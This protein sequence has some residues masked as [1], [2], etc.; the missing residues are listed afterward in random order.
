LRLFSDRESE[1]TAREVIAKAIYEHCQA[2][3]LSD[4]V[5]DTVLSGLEQAG[6][7]VKR[8]KRWKK[9]VENYRQVKE[10]DMRMA[11]EF[12]RDFWDN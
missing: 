8:R 1:M 7:V 12:N 10:A 9:L 2:S 6:Y 3:G 5:A 11:V 4:E